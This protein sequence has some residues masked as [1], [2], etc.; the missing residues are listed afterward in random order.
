MLSFS[1]TVM[2]DIKVFQMHGAATKNTRSPIIV[3]KPEDGVT[4]ADIEF[5][6]YRAFIQFHRSPVL[7]NYRLIHD[8]MAIV[9]GLSLVLKCM[10]QVFSKKPFFLIIIIIIIRQLIRHRNMSIK[11]LQVLGVVEQSERRCTWST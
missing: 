6:S 3:K 2:L 7:Q 9:T 1:D 5:V 8:S 4:R 11:S 10:M